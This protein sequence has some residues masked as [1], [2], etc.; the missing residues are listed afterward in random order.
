M[1]KNK[2]PIVLTAIHIAE[3]LDVSRT[4]AYQI[5][6]QRDFPLI[7]IGKQKRAGREAFFNWLDDRVKMHIGSELNSSADCNVNN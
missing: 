7:R 6:E 4:Y 2:Y 3:I 1:D 5:M